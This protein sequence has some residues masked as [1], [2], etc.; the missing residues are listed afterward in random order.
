MKSLIVGGDGMVGAALTKA[1][2]GKSILFDATTRH[3]W[4]EHGRRFLDL[5]DPVVDWS[6]ADYSV[7]Y[8]VAAVPKFAECES[9]PLTWLINV[10]APIA[11]ARVFK[12]AF[13]V[14]VSSDAV[15]KAGGTAYG[16]QK[17][18]VEG[19]MQSIDAA[20]VRPGRI[21]PTQADDFAEY[22]ANVGESQNPGLFRWHGH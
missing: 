7:V 21:A 19:Y 20:I 11:L 12:T 18:H 6:V 13:K 2:I 8:L 3:R 1:L 10:D 5:S 15:E 9:N 4:A 16:R 14:F 22:L 17:A